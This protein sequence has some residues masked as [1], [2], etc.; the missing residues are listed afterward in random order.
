MIRLCL[1][2]ILVLLSA[3]LW[4]QDYQQIVTTE[5]TEIDTFYHSYIVADKYRWLENINSAETTDWIDRENKQSS[6]YLSKALYKT[7]AF[8][9][10]DK[11]ALTEYSNPVKKGDYY[12]SYAY[13][14]NLNNPALFYRSSYNTSPSIIVDPDYISMKDEIKLKGYA[15]SKDSKLLAYMFNRNGSDWAEIKVVSLQNGIHKADH[16]TGVKFSDVAWLGDGYFYTTFPQEEQFSETHGQRIF[17]HKIGTEQQEDK[18]IFGRK[19][20]SPV[21]CDYI[22]TS[23]ERFFVLKEINV[24][25]GNLNLFFI[26]YQS[27]Q[28]VLRPLIPNLKHDID[29]LD[30][31]NGKFIAQSMQEANN[32][33]IVEIDPANPFKWRAIS[34]EFSAAILL[35]AIPFKDRIV[36]VYQ[37]GQ[38]PI[39]T[40]ID[41]SGTVLYTLKMPVASTVNG[42]NG[43]STDEELFFNLTSY[44]IP[45]V[46]YKFNI[47]TFKKEPAKQ[48]SVNF[49]YTA[50]EYK[51]VEYQ[52]KDDVAV[53]MVLVYEKGLKQDGNN[54]VI[55]EA[56]GGFGVVNEPSF[57]PGIVYFIKSGGIYAFA[58][59][60]GGGDEGEKWAEYGRGDNKQ[61]SFDDFIAAA[62]YLIANKYT[63][64]DKLASTG[65]SN[66][67]LVVAVAAIQRPDL[68]KAVVPV[69]APLDMLRFEKF[70][71]GHYHSDEYGTVKDSVSFTKLYGYSP[72]HNILEG[73]NY[74]AMLILTSDNDDRVPP[75]HSY[76]FAAELQSR[77]AQKNPVIL[78]S[79][80]NSG[81]SGAS[82]FYTT[83]KEKANIY[84]FIMNELTER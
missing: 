9:Q 52:S 34:T 68:F 78:K 55:L 13:Y 18:L 33:S 39:I 65:A 53:S 73:T 56:Y 54:P 32:G 82:T 15:V 70:T 36:A 6:G 25:T 83:L 84:G 4:G 1:I 40:V 23:D 3:V 72:Y 43:N 2:F 22:V 10:I 28:P 7:N 62:E 80:K 74:P 37:A 48:T 59:I 12:F 11:Y 75:F 49:D 47:R 60:R 50:I 14:N 71:I 57:D 16:L 17:Y 81:H 30:S 46:V 19:N 29:I 44:T 63:N 42:F 31:H 58:N 51:E 21:Q 67:G 45:P 26:D 24:R 5:R 66:G 35:K 38:H 77:S 61:K 76:K 27:E 8:N 20:N 79:E 41:Y 69:V 64:R